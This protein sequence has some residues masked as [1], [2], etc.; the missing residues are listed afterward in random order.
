MIHSE[1]FVVAG[2]QHAVDHVLGVGAVVDFSNPIV[3][4][5]GV[6][7]NTVVAGGVRLRP[8]V[9]AAGTSDGREGATR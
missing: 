8:L 9:E 7:E 3:A 2:P 1:A 6:G 5:I 4:D